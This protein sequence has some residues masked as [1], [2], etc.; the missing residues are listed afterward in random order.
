MQGESRQPKVVGFNFCVGHLCKAKVNDQKF[1]FKLLCKSLMQSESRQPKV[2]GFNF[3][4]G[5]L[6]KAKV[7]NQKLWVLT[8]VLVTY[9]K[10]K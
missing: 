4:V 6:C 3:C 10:R 7:D 9:A 1:V 2:V 5:H 8:F